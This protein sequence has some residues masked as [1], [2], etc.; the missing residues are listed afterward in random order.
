MEFPDLPTSDKGVSFQTHDTEYLEINEEVISQW[1][2]DIIQNEGKT[3]NQLSYIFCSD[4]FLLDLN[5]KHLNHDTLTDILTFPLSEIGPI[6][7]EIYISTD[8][9][10]DNASIFGK[11]TIGE[12]HRV[13]VHGLLH[14]CGYDDHSASDITVMREKEDYYL[15]LLPV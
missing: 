1:L 13:I 8:R 4:E 5:I 6:N 12:L 10:I 9:I 2:I 15:D 3:L 7:A 14:L 11:S